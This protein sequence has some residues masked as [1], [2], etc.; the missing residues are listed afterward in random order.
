MY[1]LYNTESNVTPRFNAMG[2]ISPELAMPT[3]QTP[4]L[5]QQA[6]PSAVSPDQLYNQQIARRESNNTM[7]G[8]H[9]PEKSTAY[10]KFGITQ[11]AYMDIQKA[12]PYF[13]GKDI[14]QLNEDE[15]NRANLVYRGVL[16]NQLKAQGVEPTTENLQAA[17]FMGAK[18]LRD[19]LTTGYISPAAAKANGGEEQVRKI[20]TGILQ[21]NQNIKASGAAIVQAQG[22]PVENITTT[23]NSIQND[24]EKYALLAYDKNQPIALQRAATRELFNYMNH[25]K[26]VDDTPAKVQPLLQEGKL[27]DVERMIKQ[28]SKTNEEGGSY[29]KAYLF[30]LFG[31]TAQ[32]QQELQKLFPTFNWSSVS[33]GGSNYSIKTDGLG[34]VREAFDADGVAQDSKVIAKIQANMLPKGDVGTAGAT[35]IRDENG[36][37]WSVVPTSTGSRFY[38]NTGKQ[39]TPSGKTIPITASTDYSGRISFE[40]DK[41][42][43]ELAKRMKTMDAA[44]RI[45]AYEEENKRLVDNGQ[46]AMTLAE[47]GID[48]SGNMLGGQ[49]AAPIQAQPNLMNQQLS[50]PGSQRLPTAAVSPEQAAA[51][52]MPQAGAGRGIRGGPTVA[53]MREAEQLRESQRKVAEAGASEVAKAAGATVGQS[54]DIQNTIGSAQSAVNIIDSGEHNIGST[55]SGFVGRGPIAQAIG[56]QFE[57]KQSDNTRIVLD[58][59][60]KL[61]AEGVK[62]LGSNPSTVDLKFWIENKPGSDASPEFTKMWIQE[63]IIRLQS[64]LSTATQQIT[65]G[66]QVTAP[67]KQP[68]P[69]PQQKPKTPSVSN[70]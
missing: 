52:P 32:A 56:R 22:G 43:I 39:G 6:V 66:G 64:K 24:P 2:P 28:E 30:G 23:M 1:E 33:V 19:F 31:M 58:T 36:K 14:T 27:G 29:I 21:G 12:D 5:Q 44:S 40:S 35:R 68:T 46:P 51:Q 38:D 54:A 61:A 57:T 7:M 59:V 41:A 37:E 16:T 15:Q 4:S 26:Q 8:F 17:H 13:T 9:A 53:Q 48:A 3:L 62:T 60:T 34:R 25:Q 42:K 70:W 49:Q 67:P 10:G 47:M 65:P 69:A 63:A 11:P 50:T 45:K 20:A 55:I 18:G